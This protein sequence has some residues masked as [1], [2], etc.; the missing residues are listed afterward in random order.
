MKNILQNLSEKKL[1]TGNRFATP[2]SSKTPSKTIQPARNNLISTARNP[3]PGGAITGTFLTQDG[4]EIRY[5]RWRPATRRR[6]GTICLFS[7]RGEFIEKYFEVISD[8]RRRGFSVAI[9]DWR[10][11]GGS[12]R[13][14]LDPKKSHVVD[15]YDYQEDMRSF[16]RE[17]VLPDCPAPFYALGH[18]MGAGILLHVAQLQNCWFDRMVLSGPMLEFTNLPLNYRLTEILVESLALMGFGDNYIPTGG[19]NTHKRVS[20]E[21]G[22]FKGNLLT[23]DESRYMRNKDTLLGDQSLGLGAPTISWVHAAFKYM[24]IFSSLE[25]AE[26]IKVPLLIFSA[27]NDKVVSNQAIQEFATA[28]RMSKLIVLPNSSHEIMQE[29]DL[30]REQFWAAFDTFIPG[31]GSPFSEAEDD[32]L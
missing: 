27:G 20:V 21:L 30:L 26:A 13:L 11:Q 17:I 1:I 8:L 29:R 9:M 4:I 7:G 14:L 12:Q 28:A 25:F 16:M 31:S 19:H 22:E 23:G 10:G 15:F 3:V 5:A 18:S 32:R 6:R 2:A 24:R